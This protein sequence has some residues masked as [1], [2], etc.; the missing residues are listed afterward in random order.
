MTNTPQMNLQAQG[1][2]AENIHALINWP[3][4]YYSS[5]NFNM[6]WFV[7]N[8]PPHSTHI[9]CGTELSRPSL[10]FECPARPIRTHCGHYTHKTSAW[11]QG[12]RLKPGYLDTV[13]LGW[14]QTNAYE[15]RVNQRKMYN[16]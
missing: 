13:L 7:T 8:T 15:K 2:S 11:S 3:I 5:D 1:R 14:R 4:A 10:R 9:R 6:N 12:Q 16:I